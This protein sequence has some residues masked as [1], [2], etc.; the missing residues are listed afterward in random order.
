MKSAKDAALAL[1]CLLAF[2]L[3]ATLNSGGYRYGATDQAFYAPAA[4]KQINP[5]L[6]PR[7]APLLATQGQLT[8]VDNIVGVLGRATGLSLPAMFAA[9]YVLGLTAIAAGAAGIGV[10]LY[11]ERWTAVALVAAL[12]LRHQ[13]TKSG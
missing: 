1:L 9:L 11:R 13:I 2:I 12:T 4:L 7:D 3:L 5:S 6:F 8:F 10:Y